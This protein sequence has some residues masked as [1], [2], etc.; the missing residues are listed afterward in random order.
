MK[1]RLIE[2]FCRQLMEK[3]DADPDMSYETMSDTVSD[4]V[5]D[6]SDEWPDD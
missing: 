6:L 2:E 4:L 3:I 1:R 5:A